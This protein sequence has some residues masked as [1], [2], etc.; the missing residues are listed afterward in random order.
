MTRYMLSRLAALPLS[1]LV[2]SIMTFSF[3]HLVPGDPVDALG[4][5][6]L[7]AKEEA[8]LRREMGL[9]KPVPVQFLYWLSHVVRGDL[10]KSIRSNR[11]VLDEVLSRLG[12]SV[13]LAALSIIMALA[14]GILGGAVATRWRGTW[15]DRSIM[16][17]ATVG[18]SVP[19]YFVAT[20]FVLFIS[21][22]LPELGVVSYVPASTGLFAN[23]SSMFFPALALAILSGATFCRYVR[24][25]T[26]DIIRNAEFLRTARAKGASEARVLFRHII[27]NSLVPL[28]TVAGLQLAYLIGGAVVIES[29]FALPGLGQLLLAAIAQRDYPVIQGCV[30]L[31]ATTF[32]IINLAVDLLYPLLDPRVQ[33]ERGVR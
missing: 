17:G 11:P 23:L 20:L 3:L 32:V 13:E 15:V 30:L 1:L 26:E 28:A 21:L 12:V 18:M 31:K 9:D 24:G 6:N 29:I 14:I 19:N 2:V 16:M 5:E 4:G 7:S 25:A 10:G 27:P 8:Q 33:L 22:C